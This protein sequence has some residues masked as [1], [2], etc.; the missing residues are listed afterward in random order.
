[1]FKFFLASLTIIISSTS[2]NYASDRL[3]DVKASYEQ[4]MKDKDVNKS[5][6][7][8]PINQTTS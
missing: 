1:M 2:L 8:T 4:A 3:E 7:L 5:S 6:M